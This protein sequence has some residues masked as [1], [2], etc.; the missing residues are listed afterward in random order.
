M[1]PEPK[2]DYDNQLLLSEPVNLDDVE[3]QECWCL[4]M[5]EEMESIEENKTWCLVDL[6]ARHRPIGLKWVFKVKKDAAGAIIK[7]KARLIAKGYVQRQ[8]VDFEEVF[9]PVA[10]LESVRVVIAL[11][12]HNGWAVHH[13]DV[14]SAFLNGELKEEVYV[15]QPPDF[16]QQ[17]CE[18]KTIYSACLISCAA[19][20]RMLAGGL[21]KDA[22]TKKFMDRGM[23]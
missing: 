5:C 3:K 9:V 6:L 15:A 8:G 14:K 2:D 22:D 21:S 23:Q 7:H 4:A 18:N 16:I 12:T 1:A 11:A 13:M 19:D 17:G 20:S 10:R